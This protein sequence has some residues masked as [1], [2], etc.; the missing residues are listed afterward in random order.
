MDSE[1]ND[2]FP[3]V[4]EGQSENWN[5]TFMLLYPKKVTSQQ[6]TASWRKTA[7]R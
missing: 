7:L 6:I 4:N 3:L 2:R 5:A 1:Q